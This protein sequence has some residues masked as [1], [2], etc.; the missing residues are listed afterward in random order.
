MY[1]SKPMNITADFSTETLKAKRAWT[2]VFWALNENN[3]SSRIL[4]L[5]TAENM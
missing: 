2:K 4:Y 5:A 3:F 1:K